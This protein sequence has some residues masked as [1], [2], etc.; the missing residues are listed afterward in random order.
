[1][2]A[3]SDL[4][5]FV[6]LVKHGSLSALARDIGVTPPAVSARLAQ[7][8]RRLGVRLLN[9]TTRRL[10]MTHEGEQYLTTGSKLLSALQELDRT[11]SSS[12]AT[13]KGLLRV[14]ATFGFGRRHIAPAI[15]AFHRQ[16]PDVEVQLELTDR[17]LNLAETAFDVG[18]RFGEIPDSRLIARKVATNRR[19]VCAS[20]IYVRAKGEPDT[21]R[22]LQRHQ[23]IVLRENDTA[24]GTW[25]FSKG[26]R[27]ETVKVHGVLSSNDGE[28]T[29]VW[30]LDGQG[31]LMRSEWDATT[32]LQ[33]GRLKQLL[34]DW[35]LPPADI[36]A[37]YPERLNLTA[38][39]TAFVEF[40]EGFL[41]KG[42][43]AG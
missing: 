32:Y 34:P 7:M 19:M 27:H 17:P 22:D 38:K 23:C 5:F 8:E 39:V 14:N 15:A 2:D 31:I 41:G 42:P 36:Y 24:Y 21:P 16:Y 3:V 35:S 30:A 13:P 37:V 11:I 43:G 6:K 12:R 26:K 10:S 25:H 28:A 18:V 9:R 40:L 1:M 20:P 33:S 29:L 4:E